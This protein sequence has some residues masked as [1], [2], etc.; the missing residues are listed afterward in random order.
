MNIVVARRPLPAH[1]SPTIPMS[2]KFDAALT[3][4]LLNRK[5]AAFHSKFAMGAGHEKSKTNKIVALMVL[6]RMNLSEN[7]R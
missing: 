1:L 4:S 6:L 2:L 5:Q 7:I 3:I